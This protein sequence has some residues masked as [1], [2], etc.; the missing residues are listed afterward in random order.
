MNITQVADAPAF[1][2][3]NIDYTA[4]FLTLIKS[5]PDYLKWFDESDKI[6]GFVKEFSSSRNSEGM[7]H[8]VGRVDEKEIAYVGVSGMNVPTPEIQITVADGYRGLGYGKEML[9]SVLTWLFEN[10][11]KDIFLYRIIADNNVSEKLVRSIGGVFREPKYDIE[12][13]T[14]KTYEIHKASWIGKA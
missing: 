8:F 2:D 4:K 5:S 3:E 12:R 10:T 6:I 1:A 7:L 13:A 11:E 14:V 9:Q